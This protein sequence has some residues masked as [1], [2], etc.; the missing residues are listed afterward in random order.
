M[1]PRRQRKRWM[2]AKLRPEAN[3]LIYVFPDTDRGVMLPEG[4]PVG[5]IYATAVEPTA[6]AQLHTS[7]GVAKLMLRGEAL[8]AALASRPKQLRKVKSS[9][10]REQQLQLKRERKIT[11]SL[12]R[13]ANIWGKSGGGRRSI[14][15]GAAAGAPGLGKRK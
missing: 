5:I 7:A 10:A 14:S 13:T 15:K 3:D 8:D 11:A 1:L 6:A 4:R 12:P 2:K 9:N